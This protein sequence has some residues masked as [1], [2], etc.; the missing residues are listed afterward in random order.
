[1]VP[2]R[3]CLALGLI[4]LR[5]ALHDGADKWKGVQVALFNWQR[6][7]VRLRVHAIVDLEEFAHG[8]RS[9]NVLEPGRTGNDGIKPCEQRPFGFVLVM[10]SCSRT[11]LPEG[12]QLA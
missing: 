10:H 12:P 1:M 6:R 8:T 9:P 4:R 5:A 3:V 7:D 2:L 11:P